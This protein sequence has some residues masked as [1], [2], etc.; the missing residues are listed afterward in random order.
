MID[1][2]EFHAEALNPMAKGPMKLARILFSAVLL[3]FADTVVTADPAGTKPLLEFGEAPVT[4]VCLGDSVTGVYYHTGGRRAYPE[5]LEVAIRKVDP[6]ANIHVVNAGI[7][8]QTTKNG[9]ERLDRDVLSKHPHL[10]TVSFGLNDVA[11]IPPDDFRK[12]LAELVA[13]CRAAKSKV[14]LCT[15]NAVI[16]TGSRPIEKVVQYCDMIRAAGRELDVPVCDQYRA[17]EALRQREAWTW[18]L[19][20]SDEIHPNMAGHKLMAEELC[21]SITGKDV[22]L[23]SEGPLVPALPRTL[24]LLKQGKPVRV[25]AMPP[26]DGLIGPALKQWQD[27]ATV[28]VIPWPTAGRKLAEL[29]RAAN[30]TVR[31]LKPDLVVIA[32]PRDAAADGDEQFVKSFSWIMN[33][34]LSF[35]HQEWDCVVVHPSV[36]APEASGPRDDLVRRLVKAQDLYLIDR[37]ADDKSPA[38]VILAKWLK[39]T[40]VP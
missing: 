12:S 40:G 8:G 16:N 35:G 27:T 26:C 32:V 34:S 3:L 21:R 17:G 6:K 13:R 36:T 14:L 5:M 18:R 2:V 24:S 15:P 19:T 31:K 28:E 30:E 9:L 23:D 37:T 29:E 38:E 39:T 1:N 25:L 20:M 7:S 11:R 10:V 33:W 22:S 4:I